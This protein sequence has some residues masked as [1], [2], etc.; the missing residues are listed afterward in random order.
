MTQSLE[1]NYQKHHSDR[2]RG[3]FA[4]LEKER[5]VLFK[6]L[7]GTGKKVLDLGCRDG[8]I[9]KYFVEGNDVTGAD[10]DSS[11]LKNVQKNFGIEILHF[12]VQSDDWPIQSES[13]DVVVAGELL[14]HLYFP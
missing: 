12:D 5:G 7:V 10:I 13:F 1:Q 11:S 6:K 9:T 14:E 3:G 2:R 8:V 4:I